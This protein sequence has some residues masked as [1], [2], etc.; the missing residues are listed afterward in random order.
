MGIII[1][2]SKELKSLNLVIR[3]KNQNSLNIVDRN[4]IDE[5]IHD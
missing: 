1:H 5:Y 4:F 3:I 2:Y